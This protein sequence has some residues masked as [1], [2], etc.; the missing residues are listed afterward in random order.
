MDDLKIYVKDD[1]ELEKLLD[2]VKTFSDE[3]GME[4]GLDRCAKATFNHGKM[5]KPTNIVL[6]DNTVIK[7]L[8]Q[9]DTYKYLGVNDSNGMQHY[10]ERKN[11]E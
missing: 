8:D 6:N 3:T 1:I 11:P 2:T 9:D 7:E 10:H 5:V 4:C